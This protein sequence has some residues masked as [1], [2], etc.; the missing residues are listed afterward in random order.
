MR[1]RVVHI[2]SA[3]ECW[4]TAHQPGDDNYTAAPIVDQRFRVDKASQTIRFDPILGPLPV[5]FAISLSASATSGLPVEISAYGPCSVFGTSLS[6][7]GPGG[8]TVIARQAGDDNFYAAR[9]VAW[10]VEI[11]EVQAPR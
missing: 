6:S 11:L 2:T 5:G 10:Y 8:C 4:L 3:G 7:A 9:E 1:D